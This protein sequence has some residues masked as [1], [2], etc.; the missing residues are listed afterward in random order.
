MIKAILLSTFAICLLGG[1]AGYDTTFGVTYVTPEG[2]SLGTTVKL[3]HTP[4]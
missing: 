4:K 2:R 3:Q 1:C